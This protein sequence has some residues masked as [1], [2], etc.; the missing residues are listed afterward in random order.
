MPRL[1]AVFLFSIFDER[2]NGFKVVI[3]LIC[4]SITFV[5]VSK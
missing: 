3:V 1:A 5:F 2:L 4:A